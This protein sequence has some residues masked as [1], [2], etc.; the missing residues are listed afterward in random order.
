MVAFDPSTTAP[1][2]W[3]LHPKDTLALVFWTK[4]PANLLLNRKLLEPYRVDVHMTI[5]GWHEAEKGVPTVESAGEMLAQA[6]RAFGRVY[7]RFSPIP[8]LP[9]QELLG[10]FQRLLGYASLAGIQ[11]VFV[12]FLQPNDR[13]PETRSE[14]Q[15]F[16]LLNKMA[17]EAH[18]V[19]IKIILCSDDKSLER[20]PEA[21]FALGACVDPIDFGG[22]KLDNC[23]CVKMVDPFTRNEA[24]GHSC[25]YC[26]AG[27]LSLSPH[28]RNTIGSQKIRLNRHELRTFTE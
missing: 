25:S 8:L 24:C 27:D 20:F 12:S 18:T 28:K 1:G 5:T 4:N 23:G 2:L 14:E 19:G 10:R 22:V 3:S 21:P 17:V 13:V 26:Y 7:W 9:D 11:Q 6:S 15:R 16:D